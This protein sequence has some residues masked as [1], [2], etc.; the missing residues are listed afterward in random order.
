MTDHTAPRR[1]CPSCSHPLRGQ[2]AQPGAKL[3][4]PG[5]G[6]RYRVKSRE[7]RLQL[8]LLSALPQSWLATWRARR[9][10]IITLLVLTVFVPRLAL[11]WMA[12]LAVS[13]IDGLAERADAP[14]STPTP[15]ARPATPVAPTPAPAPPA[16]ARV[17]VAVD[18]PR[19]ARTSK[20]AWLT[21]LAGLA[22]LL[23]GGG[24]ALATPLMSEGLL[25]LPL[26]EMQVASA[27]LVLLAG[28][29]LGVILVAGAARRR[30]I[31]LGLAGRDAATMALLFGVLGL[32]G[33]GYGVFQ[34]QTHVQRWRAIDHLA[35][36]GDATTLDALELELERPTSRGT[37]KQAAALLAS[38]APQ[39][40]IR[41]LPE[42]ADAAQRQLLL[43]LA[44]GPHRGRAAAAAAAIAADE[45]APN[46][47]LARRLFDLDKPAPSNARVELIPDQ[48]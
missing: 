39:R 3:S 38:H 46:A 23:A 28:P 32:G 5:C 48:D 1:S 42:V 10:W 6:Q 41:L 31:S 40:A 14:R 35:F 30:C 12:L 11:L 19:R 17:A 33:L 4:C 18:T 34:T 26:P 45:T 15:P 29:L 9:G 47:E 43:S 24:V 16:P 25:E 27:L 20:L 36:R 13:V 22:A 44:Y 2:A 37:R 7:T 8:E 21:V